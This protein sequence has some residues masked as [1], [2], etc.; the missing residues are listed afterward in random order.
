M[1]AAL[2]ILGIEGNKTKMQT[3]GQRFVVKMRAL[4]LLIGKKS[5]RFPGHMDGDTSDNDARGGGY[6]WLA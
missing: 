3:L 5:S 1:Q 6:G 2:D 4:K